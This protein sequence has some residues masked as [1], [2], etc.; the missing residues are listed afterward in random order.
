MDNREEKMHSRFEIRRTI[1]RPIE[2]ISSLWDDPLGFATRDLSPR[3]AYIVSELLPD[4]GE[5]VVCCF[6][7]GRSLRFDLFAKVVRVNLMRRK[8]DL[9]HPGFGVRFTDATP[10]DRLRIRGALRG[11]PPP[12]PQMRQIPRRGHLTVPPPL[13]R[14]V[15]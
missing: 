2:I 9:R 14:P 5:D 4:L 11:T 7:L 3:G 1:S 6:A 10:L 8:S 13:P 15:F 12:I